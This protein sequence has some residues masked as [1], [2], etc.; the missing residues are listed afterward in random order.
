MLQFQPMGIREDYFRRIEKKRAEVEALRTNLR[1]EERYLEA[2]LDTYKL[3]PRTGEE[4]NGTGS[5]LRKGSNPDKAYQVL[6]RNGKPMHIK[7]IVEGMGLKVNRGTTQGLAGALRTYANKGHVFT[8]IEG[9]GNTYGLTEFATSPEN[10]R[11]MDL[12][13]TE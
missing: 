12:E 3:L 2:M 11:A 8:K 5:G 13:G 10:I 6:K 9:L 4:K 7:D 1:L